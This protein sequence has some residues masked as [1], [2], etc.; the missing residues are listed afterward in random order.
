MAS[1]QSLLCGFLG[2][3]HDSKSSESPRNA[4]TLTQG[5][6]S[7]E[8][9]GAVEREG[10]VVGSEMNGCHRVGSFR[11]IFGYS[12]SIQIIKKKNRFDRFSLNFASINEMPFL[13]T[14]GDVRTSTALE[15]G[16]NRF[17][18]DEYLSTASKSLTVHPHES[19]TT[20]PANYPQYYHDV[21]NLRTALLITMGMMSIP[22][23]PQKHKTAKKFLLLPR[24][25]G[26][27]NLRI[28]YGVCWDLVPFNFWWI[29]RSTCI[30]KH[31]KGS[32][33]AHE[34]LAWATGIVSQCQSPK[35]VGL[36]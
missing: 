27:L 31:A 14:H 19:L 4:S 11:R 15:S 10:L 28:W 25:L 8:L 34:P 36:Q 26:P 16:V 17:Q 32:T 3:I 30:K 24:N 1:F 35:N 2:W 12:N 5:C 20:F 6:L 13:G 21:G 22:I 23:I 7:A 18:S 9:P 29:G 33:A